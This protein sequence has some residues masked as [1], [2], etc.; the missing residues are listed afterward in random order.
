LLLRKFL[1]Q[2]TIEIHTAKTKA[3]IREADA[4]GCRS[5]SSAMYFPNGTIAKTAARCALSQ[6]CVALQHV[7]ASN[8]HAA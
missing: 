7:P 2:T 3:Q 4:E 8:R 1:E 5:G 6:R